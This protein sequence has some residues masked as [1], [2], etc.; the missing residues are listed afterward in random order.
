MFK[1]SQLE[2]KPI[3]DN[4]SNVLDLRY[5]AT[6]NGVKETSYSQ[7]CARV[8]HVIAAAEYKYKF[9]DNCNTIAKSIYNDMM[10]HRFLFNS[11]VLF[12][13]GVGMD[14]Y[15]RYLHETEFNLT[16]DVWR[17]LYQ[18]MP[19]NQMLF[20]CFIIPVY[21]SL[22]DIFNSVRD[23]A[24]ISKHGGGVGTN[25]SRLRE[26]D[27]NIAN[28]KGG[29]ASGPVTFMQ[30]WNTMGSVVVQGGKRRAALM[31]MLN[32]DHPDI[33]EFIDAKIEDGN[34][35][36]FNISVAIT[37][38]FMKA[39]ANNE[40]FELISRLDGKPIKTVKARDLWDKICAN[41]HKRGDPGIFF[42]DTAQADSI[43]KWNRNY[44]V[45]STNPC[46]T[47]D[48]LVTMSDNRV[49]PISEVIVGD[50][51]LS[52]N[53]EL[54]SIEV[55]KVIY[56]TITKKNADIIE[57]VLDNNTHL[58]LTP[59]HL[60]F[61]K[62]RLYVE[63]K[64]LMPEDEL[65][66]LIGYGFGFDIMTC[67]VQEI[68]KIENED[69]YDIKVYKNNNFFANNILVHNC[70]EQPLVINDD[71]KGGSSCN[72]GSINVFEF[73]KEN[74]H[75]YGVTYFDY[76]AFSE[77][78]IRA[79]Y[80]L[81]LVIDATSY[82][83]ENIKENTRRIRPVGLGIMGLADAAIK[84]G[85]KYNSNEFVN[86]CESIAS[87]I[88]AVSFK[89]TVDMAKYKLAFTDSKDFM[90]KI[91]EAIAIV[92]NQKNGNI[93]FRDLSEIEDL[94]FT[95][96]HTFCAINEI[97]TD[98]ERTALFKDFMRFG[99]RNSRRLSIAPTGTISLILN[100]SS[101]IEPNFAY[102]WTRDVV[103]DNNHKKQLTYKHRLNNENNKNS[104]LLVSAHDLTPEEHI[105]PVAVF[106]KYVDSA[107]SKTVNLAQDVSVD[108][109]KEVYNYCYAKHIKG[110]TVYRDGSRNAQPLK[111]V[112]NNKET[113]SENSAKDASSD[114][115]KLHIQQRSQFMS[116]LTTKSNSPWGSLYVTMNF[117]N[118]ARPFEVFLTSGKSGS[119]N[120]AITE[121][122]SRIISL[123]LRA[124]VSLTDVIKTI[125]GISGSEVWVYENA[126]GAEVY[127]KSIPDAISRMLEDLETHYRHILSSNETIKN[128]VVSISND[129]DSG[130]I[131]MNAKKL[132]Y[133]PE[134]GCKLQNM[135]AC[136]LCPQCGWSS[137][138]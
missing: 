74:E 120:K 126:S 61:T 22:E 18:N 13:A 56:S 107:I 105:A 88:A 47:G 122:L 132:I 39:V 32:I 97:F 116:G 135:S 12:S 108:T 129:T 43:L 75:G 55:K 9:P 127:V 134:C 92:K 86:F 137:C 71:N 91:Y 83:L 48:T 66:Q 42:I 34:L 112:E 115:N 3:S 31:G 4:A 58:K 54:N 106:A 59:D 41:A 1:L 101:S 37:D 138:K 87:T 72:L 65:I 119:E 44:R 45:E 98:K 17:E 57:L 63:A 121:A 103:V 113:K 14:Y 128:N 20:A 84:L 117:D 30:T 8:A 123:A 6:F 85:I 2:E 5:Y 64:D 16:D 111:K 27:A 19:E 52:Y 53:T 114:R 67:R 21:D 36:Y 69:V 133:C 50:E 24:I 70:G 78:I 62:N 7:L 110:I 68:H 26:K 109:V 11:P 100:T 124:G 89:A 130:Q 46:L 10:S 82:P 118:E 79:M 94:P 77:Q 90:T 80:Y 99:I 104:G 33:E 96:K 40:D 29:K 131:I 25:F 125:R 76:A 28:G 38:K 93:D 81:D 35:S 49:K 102:E 73:V 51:V 136:N 95:L 15:E 60:V 23:A